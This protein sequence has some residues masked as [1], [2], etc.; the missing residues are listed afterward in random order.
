MAP[1][2]INLVL[3]RFRL[4]L[5]VAVIPFAGY[6]LVQ[7]VDWFSRQEWLAGATGGGMY[8]WAGVLD[9]AGAA[10]FRFAL[11]RLRLRGHVQLL[12]PAT[13][14]QAADA[15]HWLDAAEMLADFARHEPPGLARRP[16]RSACNRDERAIASVLAGVNNDCGSL[17]ARAGNTT[18]ADK[19][20]ARA[21]AW[22][23]FGG[24]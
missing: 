5:A 18:A 14:Q 22:K 9:G 13:S 12:L 4:P 8:G 21:A 6:A 7:T 24:L 19:H 1:L 3:A 11:P 17:Y 20:F 2:L 16:A 23:Q 15:G 10:A